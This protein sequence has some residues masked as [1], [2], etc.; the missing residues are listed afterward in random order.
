MNTYEIEFYA[1]EGVK[2]TVKVEVES[3]KH[4]AFTFEIETIHDEYDIISIT[5]TND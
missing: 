4:A 1:S 2:N 5:K 3:F